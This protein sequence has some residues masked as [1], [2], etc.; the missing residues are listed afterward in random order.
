M[1]R[2]LSIDVG[3]RH[4]AFYVEEFDPRLFQGLPKRQSSL[5]E[6]EKNGKRVWA[7]VV[8]LS[9]TGGDHLDPQVFIRLTNFLDEH[10]KVWDRCSFFLIE[11]QLKKNYIMVRLQ[12]HCQSYFSIFYG[13]FK[14]NT[15][16]Q[17]SRKTKTYGQSGMTKPQRKGWA[18]NKATQILA[19]RDDYTG[20]NLLL[21]TYKKKA[22][23][24]DAIVQLQAFKYLVW[25]E[26]KM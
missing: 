20:L 14:V 12:Q 23:L 9:V 15:E 3:A 6:I 21:V 5:K 10:R 17:S 26:G 2:G 7:S 1:I 19:N 16:I 4:M 8:D 22:D 11:K 18:V 13:D 24:P 25:V